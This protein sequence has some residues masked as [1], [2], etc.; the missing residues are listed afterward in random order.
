MRETTHLLRQY[1]VTME[2]TPSTFQ[3]IGEALRR[4]L[5]NRLQEETQRIGM[6]ITDT[7]HR[8]QVRTHITED[9]ELFELIQMACI[10]TG[11]LTAESA[12][13][14]LHKMRIAEAQQ[15]WVDE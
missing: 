2:V 11:Y 14:T 1:A 8:Q 4:S 13:Q 5:E 9:G 7:Q 6:A 12:E 15:E 3:A 10:A